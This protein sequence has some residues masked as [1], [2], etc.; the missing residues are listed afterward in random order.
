VIGSNTPPGQYGQ[1]QA[2]LRKALGKVAAG[3]GPVAIVRE[4]FGPR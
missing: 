3:A 4:V 1:A 2:R